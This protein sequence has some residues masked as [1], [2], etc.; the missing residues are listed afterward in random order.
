MMAT[1]AADAPFA[2]WQ[3]V[4]PEAGD[5]DPWRELA[6]TL[7]QCAVPPD[8][9]EWLEPGGMPGLFAGDETLPAVPVGA[10]PVLAP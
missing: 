4:V 9:I 6:R 10:P 8:R 1:A 7:V 3:V 2:S 5:F